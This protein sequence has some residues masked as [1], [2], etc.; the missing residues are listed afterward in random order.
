M[1]ALPASSGACPDWVRGFLRGDDLVK[2]IAAV[3]H[4]VMPRISVSGDVP[5]VL[6]VS[7]DFTGLRPAERR[8]KLLAA[9]CSGMSKTQKAQL[10]KSVR[11]DLLTP[12]QHEWLFGD[13]PK[14]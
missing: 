13:T 9:A 5:K 10:A 7:S 1:A 8:R 2:A 4:S 14:Q 3:S 11:W 6:V 12:Q